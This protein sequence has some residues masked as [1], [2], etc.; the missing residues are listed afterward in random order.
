MEKVKKIA[1]IAMTVGAVLI[2]IAVVALIAGSCALV[3]L[4]AL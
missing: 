3:Y 4:G 2:C 1:M